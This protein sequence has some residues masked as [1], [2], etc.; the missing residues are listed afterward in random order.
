MTKSKWHKAGLG[1]RRMLMANVLK[2]D[3]DRRRKQKRDLDRRRQQQADATMQP[4]M[5]NRILDVW[6]RKKMHAPLV[7]VLDARARSKKFFERLIDITVQAYDGVDTLTIEFNNQGCEIALI[8]YRDPNELEEEQIQEEENK[9]I[10]IL[11]N[12]MYTHYQLQQPVEFDL[13]IGCAGRVENVQY[14]SDNGDD[15]DDDYEDIRPNED[16]GSYQLRTNVLPAM[17][18]L[19]TEDHDDDRED[20]TY[21][22]RTFRMTEDVDEVQ[23]V[24]NWNHPLPNAAAATYALGKKGGVSSPQTWY[25]M[26]LNGNEAIMQKDLNENLLSNGMCM[27]LRNSSLKR[28]SKARALKYWH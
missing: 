19:F 21:G 3:H 2:R 4:P 12:I 24:I 15:D 7:S 14:P 26:L 25:N 10:R 20:W 1:T 6:R 28:L 8:N 27:I 16:I 17:R 11:Y 22:R 18:T 13:F 9:F 5:L 23:C